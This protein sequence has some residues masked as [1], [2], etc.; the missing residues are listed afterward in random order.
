MSWIVSVRV[1]HVN[2]VN[3]LK[4]FFQ[5]YEESIKRDW[6]IIETTLE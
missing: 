2:F 1:E 6:V 4:F 3:I 5:N